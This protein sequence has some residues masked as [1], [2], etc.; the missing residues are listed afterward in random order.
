MEHERGKALCEKLELSEILH[1]FEGRDVSAN[2]TC[3]VLARPA[4]RLDDLYG[5]FYP[6]CK[7]AASNFR[8]SSKLP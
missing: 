1:A 2:Q 5:S 7:S 3:T 4:P 8:S 6:L